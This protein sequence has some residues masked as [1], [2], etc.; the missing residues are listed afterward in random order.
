MA[1]TAKE[2]LNVI[3][4]I[5]GMEDHVENL[6]KAGALD[7]ALVITMLNQLACTKLIIKALYAQNNDYIIANQVD[8]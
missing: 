7:R 1:F 2:F 5:E 4:E 6:G 3:D 8:D